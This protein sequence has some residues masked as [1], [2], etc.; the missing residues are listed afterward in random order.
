MLVTNTRIVWHRSGLILQIRDMQSE[1][2]E[3]K[4]RRGCDSREI[5]ESVE[6]PYR[7]WHMPA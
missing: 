6:W 4:A 5:K 7:L 2:S 3:G 1:S